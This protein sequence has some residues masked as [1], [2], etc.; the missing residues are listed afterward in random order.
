LAGSVTENVTKLSYASER[1]QA[2]E[3]S[4]LRSRLLSSDDFNREQGVAMSITVSISA[5]KSH[6]PDV[7][8]DEMSN[9]HRS[10][11]MIS[12]CMVADHPCC[13]KPHGSLRSFSLTGTIFLSIPSHF[14]RIQSSRS[15]YFTS[16]NH[17]SCGFISTF[18]YWR[19]AS[20]SLHAHQTSAVWWLWSNCHDV[21][22][23]GY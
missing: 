15:Q 2:A 12:I 4:Q 16:S 17:L 1:M 22:R 3:R 8:A 5:V 7:D 14:A 6:T 21:T 20:K 13:R 23:P 10:P 19:L 9:S 11:S 18:F